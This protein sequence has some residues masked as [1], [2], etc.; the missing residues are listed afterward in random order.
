LRDLTYRFN[1]AEQSSQDARAASQG[2]IDSIAVRV[3][4]VEREE[5]SHQ[6]AAG[7]QLEEVRKRMSKLSAEMEEAQTSLSALAVFQA[8][9]EEATAVAAVTAAIAPPAPAPA[10]PAPPPPPPPPPPAP[11]PQDI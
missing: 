2:Q 7:R 4:D 6:L 9:T 11:K 5:Q 10:P 8:K 1:A 3:V